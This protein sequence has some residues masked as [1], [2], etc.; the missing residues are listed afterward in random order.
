[1][2]GF[3]LA[4]LMVVLGVLAATDSLVREAGAA[5]RD[6]KFFYIIPLTDMLVFATLV[7]FAFRNRFN[8]AAH[9]RLLMIATTGLMIAAVARWPWAFVHRQNPRGGL[10]RLPLSTH[11]GG[12]RSVVDAQGA[13]GNALG[14]RFPGVRVSD[15]AT[16]R[17][18]GGV[19]RLC[20]VGAETGS[21][22][23]FVLGDTK[24]ISRDDCGLA[25]FKKRRVARH[26]DAQSVDRIVT[27]FNRTEH[28]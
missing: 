26:Q 9:K 5:R 8:A 19:A 17:E 11:P 13:S 1:M 7:Y 20:G 2:A 27:P 22:R 21:V 4:C 15:Q 3:V 24:S 28:D 18:D 25:L 6:P 23:G 16:H 10:D 12:L 14:E